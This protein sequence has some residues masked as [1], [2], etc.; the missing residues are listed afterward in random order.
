M[1][2]NFKYVHLILACSIILQK[3][4]ISSQAIL[5]LAM[6]T[7]MFGYVIVT[8]WQTIAYDPCTEYSPFHHPGIAHQDNIN[9]TQQN[10][11]FSSH[12]ATAMHI[13]T[14]AKRK[15]S[16]LESI[17]FSSEIN[18]KVGT[19]SKSSFDYQTEF[20][21]NF[22]CKQIKSCDCAQF[23][24]RCLRFSVDD[25]F[26][27]T[28]ARIDISTK[29]D[30][31]LYQCTSEFGQKH[32]GI[33]FCVFLSKESI[34]PSP[35]DET[36]IESFSEITTEQNA[37]I[38]SIKILP[39]EFYQT[40]R[41]NC[42]QANVPGHQCHWIPD[43]DIFKKECEDCQPICRSVHQTLTFAQFIIGNGL[44]ILSSALQF[45]PVIS[46]LMNQ[47]PE[48]IRVLL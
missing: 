5:L 6:L 23:P 36:E 4:K 27:I 19:G 43:S 26:E 22:S 32:P 47:S 28:R 12:E 46:L 31:E 17:T 8:D 34:N 45:V 48:Q 21:V 15:L 35:T 20:G 10:F 16:M 18:L 2:G 30:L 9:L 11:E 7:T 14:M 41:N 37:I 13:Q 3:L 44:L 42:I 24:S 38:S 29:T 33:Q 39:E 1:I 40:A 25:E